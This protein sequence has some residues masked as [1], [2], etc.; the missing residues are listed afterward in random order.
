M[1]AMSHLSGA[2]LGPRSR[3]GLGQSRMRWEDPV[4]Q[5][6]GW[7][8]SC[9]GEAARWTCCFRRDHGLPTDQLFSDR[10]LPGLSSQMRG[11][12]ILGRKGAPG[13]WASGCQSS[14][15]PVARLPQVLPP[16]GVGMTES[17]DGTA[18]HPFSE[19]SEGAP[20]CRVHARKSEKSHPMFDW[21]CSGLL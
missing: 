5:L 12:P 16:T 4:C 6:A 1:E 15:V 20:A 13:L 14:A 8:S 19:S 21:W 10:R 7:R 18:R 17:D 9:K 11:G 2:R 3:E